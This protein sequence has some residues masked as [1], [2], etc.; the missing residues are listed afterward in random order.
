[1]PDQ[2]VIGTPL[3][4]GS[5]ITRNITVNFIQF[6]R[7]VLF[8]S[9]SLCRKSPLV[10]R[11]VLLKRFLFLSRFCK[12]L[13]AVSIISTGFMPFSKSFAES[14][15]LI[16]FSSWVRGEWRWNNYRPFLKTEN[17][18]AHLIPL[19]KTVRTFERPIHTLVLRSKSSKL[20]TAYSGVNIVNVYYLT[21]NR[22]YF[23]SIINPHL[24][25]K[26]PSQWDMQW[27]AINSG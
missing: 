1:M 17:S 4:F 18:G 15:H 10:R 11:T 9:L 21:T 20:G 6:L 8:C 16:L 26:S 7:D 3:P 5:S 23:E 25:R 2:S 22:L 14:H 13:H 24:T 12:S 27:I 19:S